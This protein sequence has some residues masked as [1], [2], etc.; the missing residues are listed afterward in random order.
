MLRIVELFLQIRRTGPG[1]TG[2]KEW[3][4]LTMAEERVVDEERVQ[5]DVSVIAL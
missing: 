5:V 4:H 3:M 2:V 1:P